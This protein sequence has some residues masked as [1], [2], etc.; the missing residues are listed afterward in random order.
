MPLSS[1]L[2]TIPHE[3]IHPCPN[4]TLLYVCVPTAVV[5]VLG[6][7]VV[8]SIHD[9]LCHYSHPRRHVCTFAYSCLPSSPHQ[10]LSTMRSP[11]PLT[12]S[13]APDPRLCVCADCC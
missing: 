12:P 10:H 7:F 4:Q 9:I 11:H 1:S 6:D 8:L 2:P 13:P 5:V 3:L